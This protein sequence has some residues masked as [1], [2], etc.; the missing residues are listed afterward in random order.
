MDRPSKWVYLHISTY[1]GNKTEISVVVAYPCNLTATWFSWYCYQL[2]FGEAFSKSSSLEYCGGLN[3]NGPGGPYTPMLGHQQWH[4]LIRNNRCDFVGGS[5]PLG[6]HFK[7][8]KAHTCPRA[9]LFLLLADQDVELSTTSLAPW[10][11]VC[12]HVPTMMKMG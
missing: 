4:Y 10:L 3:K 9:S 12:S 2:P 11:T 5:V 6:V 8:S 7:V 1:H